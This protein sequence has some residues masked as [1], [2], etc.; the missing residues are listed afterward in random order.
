MS[1]KG[2]YNSEWYIIF[3]IY[4]SLQDKKFSIP[5]AMHMSVPDLCTLF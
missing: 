4:G 3:L 1:C 2:S 5:Y